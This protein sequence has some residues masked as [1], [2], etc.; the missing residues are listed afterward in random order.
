MSTIHWNALALIGLAL[1]GCYGANGEAKDGQSH[2]MTRCSSQSD[3][4]SDGMCACGVCTIACG[5][6]A[7]CG[8]EASCVTTEGLTGCENAPSAASEVC[9]ATCADEGDCGDSNFECVDGTCMAG[10][11]PEIP[12]NEPPLSCTEIDELWRQTVSVLTEEHSACESELDCTCAP[13]TTVCHV[14]CDA[15]IRGTHA[16]AFQDGIASFESEYCAPPGVSVLCM[17]SNSTCD[18]CVAVCEQN[19][20]TQVSRRR[21]SNDSQCAADEL[22]HIDNTCMVPG[23][24]DGNGIAVLATADLASDEISSGVGAFA[25]I[26]GGIV[27]M[28]AR[29]VHRLD[30]SDYSVT[31]LHDGFARADNPELK[32]DAERAYYTTRSGISSARLDG[33]DV[34]LLIAPRD[35]ALGL[36]WALDSGFVYYATDRGTTIR[37]ASSDGADD[38]VFF[39]ADESQAVRGLAIDDTHVFVELLQLGEPLTRVAKIGKDGSSPT[40]LVPE[41]R[42]TAVEGP[43]L[44]HDGRLVSVEE[45]NL[46]IRAHSIETGEGV[47][48]VKDEIRMPALYLKSVSSGYVYFSARADRGDEIGSYVARVSMSGGTPQQLRK[49][50]AV[51]NSVVAVDGF[52]YWDE[53]G[54]LLRKRL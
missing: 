31:A 7:S 20:C 32:V 15:S 34:P 39:E 51:G 13:L 11:G 10:P 43:L 9:L 42:G 46:G 54:R 8:A 22:C 5:D 50:M 41:F 3:C 16:G 12:E 49:S 40:L 35:E 30:L 48:L 1:S 19:R 6:E 25:L 44:V 45:G 53:M 33:G 14:S 18:E 28:S 24:L 29:S 17:F 27:L 26:E 36:A 37:R 47:V 2:W 52:L 23:S 38:V 21:C 4:P